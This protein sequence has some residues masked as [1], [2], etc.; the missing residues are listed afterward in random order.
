MEEH[1][2]HLCLVLQCLRE[3]KLYGKL[4][5]CSFYQ[6]KIHYLGHVISNEGIVVDP[7]KVE[8]I[9]EWSAPTNIPKVCSFMGLVG[10]YRRF[11]KGFSKIENL[12]TELQKKNK[13]FVWKKKCTEEF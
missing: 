6:S 3:N 7:V 13:K 1:D 11:V 4:S 8:A 9:M 2:E 12:I 5:K 10:Y